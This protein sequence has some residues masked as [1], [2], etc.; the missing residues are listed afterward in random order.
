MSTPADRIRRAL[1]FCHRRFWSQKV[2]DAIKEA[3][4]IAELE[5]ERDRHA[6]VREIITSVVCGALN[7]AGINEVDNP[8]VAIDAIRNRAENAERERDELRVALSIFY[9]A[10]ESGNSVP[11]HICADAEKLIAR[12]TRK[13]GE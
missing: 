12:P 8:G 3:S 1:G 2:K 13:D 7:R 11:P 9:H 5:R 6:E 10:H 4:A